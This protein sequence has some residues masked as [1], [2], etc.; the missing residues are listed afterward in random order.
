MCV[1]VMTECLNAKGVGDWEQKALE[2]VC[3]GQKLLLTRAS[4]CLRLKSEGCV[5]LIF[6]KEDCFF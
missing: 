6:F 5:P 3:K 4:Y 2:R 1:C